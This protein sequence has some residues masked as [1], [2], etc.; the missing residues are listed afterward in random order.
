MPI[1]FH[2]PRE[3]NLFALGPKSASGESEVTIKKEQKSNAETNVT[4]TILDFCDRFLILLF[5]PFVMNRCDVIFKAE[6]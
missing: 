5:T 3:L 4:N 1:D 2:M 6:F